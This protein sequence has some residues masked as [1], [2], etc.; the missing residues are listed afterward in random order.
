M[1]CL[2]GI[3]IAFILVFVS[4]CSDHGA[5]SEKSF[6][7][8]AKLIENKT[9]REVEDLLGHPDGRDTTSRGEERW[10]WWNYTYLDG[11]SYAPEI[12]ERIVHLEIILQPPSMYNKGPK[13]EWRVAAVPYGVGY[14]LGAIDR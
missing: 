12:Q 13:S 14:S 2:A 3:S 5:R 1:R 7:E 9:A 11:E 6:D 10:I 4:S 8:I